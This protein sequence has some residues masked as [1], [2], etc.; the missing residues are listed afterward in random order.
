MGSLPFARIC[1][2]NLPIHKCYESVLTNG[3]E[4][5]GKPFLLLS[6][7]YFIHKHLFQVL[8]KRLRTGRQPKP[9]SHQI[10]TH[11]FMKIFVIYQEVSPNGTISSQYLVEFSSRY[12]L[13]V[14]VLVFR[15][16]SNF[17][18]ATP[19]LIQPSIHQS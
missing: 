1:W 2:P 19:G 6:D 4:L 3:K 5:L 12:I 18:A 16:R 9:Q 17:L 13:T 15:P 10:S 14:H 7:D 8:Q 11:A